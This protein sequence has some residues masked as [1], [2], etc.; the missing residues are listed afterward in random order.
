M[1]EGGFLSVAVE[2]LLCYKLVTAW[3]SVHIASLF[4]VVPAPP[5]WSISLSP[6][7]IYATN[8]VKIDSLNTEDFLNLL[9]QGGK[10]RFHLGFFLL[11]HSGN[12]HLVLSEE[13]FMEERSYK[14]G[15]L[16]TAGTMQEHNSIL[17]NITTRVC[18]VEM[19]LYIFKDSPEDLKGTYEGLLRKREIYQG[20][21]SK[22]GAVCFFRPYPLVYGAPHSS[23][24]WYMC[25]N[26]S[27]PCGFWN[28]TLWN[29]CEINLKFMLLFLI[30]QV[31]SPL[32]PNLNS[33]VRLDTFDSAQ[34]FKTLHSFSFTI[35][36][37]TTFNNSKINQTKSLSISSFLCPS[38]PSFLFS[39][40]FLSLSLVLILS[41][42]FR[43]SIVLWKEK[44][45]VCKLRVLL[46]FCYELFFFTEEY[47]EITLGSQWWQGAGVRESNGMWVVV[48]GNSRKVANH[49]INNIQN[50]FPS[51]KQKRGV[52]GSLYLHPTVP[53]ITTL[54]QI[55]S[56]VF[57][58]PQKPLI[59]GIKYD[60]IY[61]Y[62]IDGNLLGPINEEIFLLIIDWFQIVDLL[63]LI[64]P[65]R[66]YQIFSACYYTETSSY[67][68]RNNYFNK[69]IK[70]ISMSQG[71]YITQ[72]CERPLNYHMFL[73]IPKCATLAPKT[74]ACDRPHDAT[75]PLFNTHYRLHKFN[76][77]GPRTSLKDSLFPPLGAF[78]QLIP[79]ISLP[80]TCNQLFQPVSSH[81]SLSK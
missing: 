52:K 57:L 35:G 11:R 12:I 4:G 9:F 30:T 6:D 81:P 17:E 68:T 71:R 21:C 36:E 27:F 45:P 22:V 20:I 18:Q 72:A 40:L 48:V 79:A 66:G 14:V 25:I 26:I 16:L 70:N 37:K 33:T 38:I 62:V 31:S 77:K 78:P 49:S 29:I 3:K 47:L 8:K 69:I 54:V 1:F 67:S 51:F 73:C 44:P 65:N 2:L 32:L 7:S 28:S 56:D 61:H 53:S 24:M 10:S 19:G 63:Y 5:L 39:N 59:G 15:P 58:S 42:Q 80:S 76:P 64:R 23:I 34:A 50:L 75:K 60:Q 43:D 13:T 46:R 55:S 74:T 41:L